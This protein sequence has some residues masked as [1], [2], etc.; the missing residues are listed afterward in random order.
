ME[1]LLRA[2]DVAQILNV[3]PSTVY[4]L[5]YR[6][7]LPFYRVGKSYRFDMEQIKNHVTGK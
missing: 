2:K 7:E 5:C 4:E 3:R 1:T 6:R